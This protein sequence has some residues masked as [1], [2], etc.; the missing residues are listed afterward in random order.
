MKFQMIKSNTKLIQSG[1]LMR[2]FRICL[3]SRKVPNVQVEDRIQRQMARS[4]LDKYLR[5][6]NK[7]LKQTFRR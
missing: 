2:G 3:F 7:L 5:S 6:N 4:K 1:K